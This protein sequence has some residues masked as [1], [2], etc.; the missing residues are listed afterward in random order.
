MERISKEVFE[1]C[2]SLED[3][4]EMMVTDKDGNKVNYSD[5]GETKDFIS[6]YESF[7]TILEEGLPDLTFEDILFI[8]NNQSKVVRLVTAWYGYDRLLAALEFEVNKKKL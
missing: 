4:V 5:V 8:M 7:K 1:K 6:R 3:L 2:N